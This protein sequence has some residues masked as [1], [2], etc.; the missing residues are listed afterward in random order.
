[1]IILTTLKDALVDGTYK[2]SGKKIR[3]VVVLAV[4]RFN[5]V[6]ATSSG[7]SPVTGRRYFAKLDHFR[8]Y[9]PEYQL[10]DA[11]CL[12]RINEVFA[13]FS[14]EQVSGLSWQELDKRFAVPARLSNSSGV[15]AFYEA[16]KEK[17]WKDVDKAEA[18]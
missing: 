4:D 13:R 9:L 3:Q 16:L 12:K 7:E 10:D 18:A 14:G 1:M 8:K 5:I 17:G 2:A 6:L 15:L 11:E